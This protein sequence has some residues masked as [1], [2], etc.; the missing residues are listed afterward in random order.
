MAVKSGDKIYLV[1]EGEEWTHFI[2]ATREQAEIRA[3]ECRAECRE[4]YENEEIIEIYETE[5][6]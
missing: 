2:C 4:D 5:L 3:E 6:D 1:M